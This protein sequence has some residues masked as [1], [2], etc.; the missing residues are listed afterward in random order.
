M[1]DVIPPVPAGAA[2]ATPTT[3]RR[4]RAF[5]IAPPPVPLVVLLVTIAAVLVL[6]GCAAS[7]DVGAATGDEPRIEG[8]AADAA[9]EGDAGDDG[10][11]GRFT[12]E[13]AQAF[14]AEI[15]ASVAD[16]ADDGLAVPTDRQLPAECVAVIGLVVTSVHPLQSV[17]G[18]LAPDEQAS[19]EVL[20]G[21]WW[22]AVPAQLRE[23][24]VQTE[25]QYR[26]VAADLSIALEEVGRG[27][28]LDLEGAIEQAERAGQDLEGPLAAVDRWL[29]ERCTPDAW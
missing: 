1:S 2:P 28:E 8:G 25:E 7:D 22:D 13:V 19:V 20:R 14:D 17:A 27:G 29:H 21:D 4:R 6:T 24:L 5:A 15:L 23:P 26:Q 3:R 16:L 9:S 12:S 18:G 11:R 10:D